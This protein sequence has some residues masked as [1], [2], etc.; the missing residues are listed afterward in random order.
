MSGALNSFVSGSLTSESLSVDF[1]RGTRS[2]ERSAGDIT[3]SCT[4]GFSGE[5]GLSTSDRSSGFLSLLTLVE[6]VGGLGGESDAT[7]T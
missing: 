7:G 1:S 6:R 2:G 4:R 5:S 3:L